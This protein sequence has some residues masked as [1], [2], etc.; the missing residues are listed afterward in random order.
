MFARTLTI[1]LLTLLK[2]TEILW[3]LANILVL[4]DLL[5]FPLNGHQGER[6]NFILSIL[7]ILWPGGIVPYDIASHYAQHERSVILSAMA[8]FPKYTC[9]TFRPRTERDLYYLSINKYY[10][11][12][13]V[14]RQTSIYFRTREGKFETRM[15]LHESCLRY[16]ER[17]RGTVMH[18][19]MHALGFHHE[20]QR[21]DRDPRVKGNSYWETIVY[22]RNKAYYMGAYD[23]T[24]IMH[25]DFP[26]LTYPRTH[27][28]RSDIA[29]INTLYRCPQAKNYFKNSLQQRQQ[30]S[31]KRSPWQYER[32]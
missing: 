10:K 11:Q 14:G 22:P 18:E 6:F 9:I 32:M 30:F 7:H 21:E 27:F 8:E 31:Q 29:R 23:P 12:D 15:R 1:C 28:S 2:L 3:K 13:Y 26:G 5:F 19:L 24:S 16:G 17:G 4:S 20:H 25:Y